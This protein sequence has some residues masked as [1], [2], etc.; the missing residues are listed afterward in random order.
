MKKVSANDP[1]QTLFGAK[2]RLYYT[3]ED[4]KNHYY[5]ASD[6][7]AVG[8]T[9]NEEDATLVTDANGL[10]KF[11]DLPDGT[12]YLEE[13]SA[14]TGFWPIESPIA[15][16]II[17]RTLQLSDS[18]LPV[19]VFSDGGVLQSSG[20]TL[21]TITV[22]NTLNGGYELPETGGCGTIIYMVSGLLL[23]AAALCGYIIKRRREGRFCK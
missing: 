1:S 8:W 5:K 6:S 20:E 14:P 17:D 3:D 2:F 21:Y 9:V 23:L 22:P 10:V 13:V 19:G 11:P 18:S 15:L 4:G 7:G 16:Q 12:Y